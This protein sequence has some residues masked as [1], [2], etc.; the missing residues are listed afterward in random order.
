MVFQRMIGSLQRN[1]S[2]A[3][4]LTR[5]SGIQVA[6]YIDAS[7]RDT[8]EVAST[9]GS[10]PVGTRTATRAPVPFAT[11]T[12]LLTASQLVR[13]ALTVVTWAVIAR[14]LGPKAL[15]EIQFAYLVPGLVLLLTNFGLPLAN[16]YFLGRQAYPLSR[17]LG[18]VLL[19]W[20]IETCV[21]VPL[22]FLAR[23]QILTYVPVST[24]IYAAI[25][26]WIPLQTL[27]S[28]LMSILTAQMRF[29]E[30][31]W[32]NLVQGAAVIIA[33]LVAVGPLGLGTVGA[34]AGLVAAT[35]IVLLAEMWF[36]R[37]G[38]VLHQ[39]RPPARLIRNCL[40]FGLRGYF[41]NLAQF[42]TYR[43]DS[44]IVSY[45][46]GVTALGLYAAAYT[47]AEMLLYFPTCLATVMFPATAA[48]SIADANWRTARVSRLTFAF[49]LLGSIA[50]AAVAPWLFRALLGPRFTYS[51]V[52]FWALLPGIIMLAGAKI[53][54][55]DLL[56]RGFPQLSSRGSLG[57]MVA[58]GLLDVW[59][60]PEWGLIA[61]A[62]ISSL[63]Y[64]CQAVYWIRCLKRVT[65]MKTS[66]LLVM[67]RDD[68][69][70]LTTVL[71]TRTNPLRLRLR[72]FLRNDM[73]GI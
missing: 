10:S 20:L 50:G 60:I 1:S 33:V 72:S 58:I 34:V 59:L 44:F 29:Y 30:Q 53:I 57:G 56:G 9:S 48:S 31:F 67:T 62:L 16:I 42:V 7:G 37:H 4:R 14:L 6:T 19:R 47:A 73:S 25:I 35:C 2:E 12:A 43:F 21:V 65:G 70:V 36:L 64:G 27:N 26:C 40:R 55:A 54:T 69:S 23:G 71:S 3:L 39:L 49:A 61:A 22:L 11:N 46:L 5:D 63:V 17:M 45:L 13:Y 28:Y 38:L 68:L 24:Q 18:N 41:A 66:E 32:I 51:V 15:G 8:M 52:L